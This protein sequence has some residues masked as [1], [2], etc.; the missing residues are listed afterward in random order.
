MAS[1]VLEGKRK[2]ARSWGPT[3]QQPGTRS[4]EPG[5]VVVRNQH[6]RLGTEESG[7][8]ISP[9]GHL[10]NISNPQRELDGAQ[11]YCGRKSSQGPPKDLLSSTISVQDKVVIILV[12][13]LINLE[14]ALLAAPAWPGL[15]LASDG[16]I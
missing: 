4:P 10:S 8:R 5:V 6:R 9:N 16:L 2:G 7:G 11:H 14:L 1:G 12:I 15:A 3:A 13:I